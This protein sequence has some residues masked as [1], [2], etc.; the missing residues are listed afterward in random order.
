[1]KVSRVEGA[2]LWLCIGFGVACLLGALV[3]GAYTLFGATRAI[4]CAVDACVT[5]THLATILASVIVGAAAVL[6]AG[7]VV[8][9]RLGSN[10]RVRTT[11]WVR[12]F[13][14]VAAVGVVADYNLS[15]IIKARNQI[16][17]FQPT[18]EQ[19]WT[20]TAAVWLFAIGAAVVAVFALPVLDRPSRLST[21]GIVVGV[22]AAMTLTTV[23][24]A[25]ALHKGDD[26]QYIDATTAPAQAVP[27]LPAVLGQQRFERQLP[28][29]S[30][31]EIYPAGAGF[32][33]KS[34]YEKDSDV[35][36][37]VA[38][39][40]SGEERWHYRR[41]GPVPPPDASGRHTMNVQDLAYFDDGGIV[42]LSFFSNK[43]PYVGLDAV[44]GA[45][46]W[47]STDPAIGS[48]LAVTRSNRRSPH[49][50]GRLD[51]HL[52]A[53]DPQTGR[54]LWSIDDP[55]HCPPT[56]EG[57]VP[58]PNFDRMHVYSVDT[59]TRI[60]AV[61]DCSTRKKLDL[62][63]VVVDPGTGAVTTDKS[64]TSLDGVARDD[65]N[66]WAAYPVHGTDAVIVG[67]YMKV[68]SRYLY[69]DEIGK[70]T[71]FI[72]P[73]SLDAISDGTFTVRNQ[74]H[75]R[76]YS[77]DA[78]PQCDIALGTTHSVGYT[79]LRDQVVVRDNDASAL[80]VFDRA[81]CRRVATVPLPAGYDSLPIPV[82]GATLMTRTDK[83]KRTS[84]LGF[85]P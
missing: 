18:S 25:N 45:Q 40:A 29:R 41:T 62:Q 72:E 15:H 30:R 44:T 27:P 78:I 7:L 46:L 56:D 58:L 80:D 53:L 50:V 79:I 28:N 4:A 12:I 69:I 19:M 77:G 73:D 8:L 51:G 70:H 42:V 71:D 22:V 83:D 63:L 74:D 5:T 38:Y 67:L 54:R 35:P 37:V 57:R 11:M 64:L 13:A 6:L 81:S 34:D 61:V 52:I 17:T 14:A 48:V 82:R 85:M 84:V 32:V 39:G 33:V 68:P 55:R 47:T 43:G 59:K 2:L 9:T 60:G 49:F 1:M 20:I 21:A 24:G 36:D 75:L 66:S 31:V 3:V 76:L 23:L 65:L 10:A 26:S 16:D